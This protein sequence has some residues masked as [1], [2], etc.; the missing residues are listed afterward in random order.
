MSPIVPLTRLTVSCNILCLGIDSIVYNQVETFTI[1]YDKVSVCI[2]EHM[3]YYQHKQQGTYLH[4]M[5]AY[6][7]NL[8]KPVLY[9]IKGL[10]YIYIRLHWHTAG[11]RMDRGLDPRRLDWT[12]NEDAQLDWLSDDPRRVDRS[13]GRRRSG[14]LAHRRST[15]SRLIGRLSK[16]HRLTGTTTT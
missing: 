4:A 9:I 16:T 6:L 14:R 5:N 2:K 13:G 12:T 7:M 3:I 15:T 10:K 11:R 8:R 1:E